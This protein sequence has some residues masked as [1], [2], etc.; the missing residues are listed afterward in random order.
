ML[1]YG[2]DIANQLRRSFVESG[3]S[4]KK[5]LLDIMAVSALLGIEKPGVI[6]S[7]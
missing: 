2:P 1:A 6:R 7:G 4:V 5:L 3:F